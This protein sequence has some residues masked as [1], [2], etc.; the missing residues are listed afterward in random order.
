MAL[1][2]HSGH[3]IRNIAEAARA[4][5]A[6]HSFKKI[7]EGTEGYTLDLLC[8]PRAHAWVLG[9]CLMGPVTGVT[10]WDPDLSRRPEPGPAPLSPV[11]CTQM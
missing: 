11:S 9:P 3:D 8:S 1:G 10:Y 5:P 2:S 4:P 6:W 7:S